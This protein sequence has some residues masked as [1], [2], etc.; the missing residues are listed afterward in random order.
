[1]HVYM[2]S[3]FWS[4]CIIP[5]F[6]LFRASPSPAHL[7]NTVMLIEQ[8]KSLFFSRMYAQTCR[9]RHTYRNNYAPPCIFSLILM[10]NHAKTHT[11]T[12][13]HTHTHVWTHPHPHLQPHPHLNP[14]PHPHLHPRTYTHTYTH[15]HNTSRV[16]LRWSLTQVK[17]NTIATIVPTAYLKSDVN[18]WVHIKCLN[19]RIS[20][21]M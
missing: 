13:I 17:K 2:Y 14:H 7:A 8:P 3:W 11:N 19:M 12:R 16:F 5:S 9:R 1:M 20:M 6:C 10:T 15:T 4:L 21:N 18:T